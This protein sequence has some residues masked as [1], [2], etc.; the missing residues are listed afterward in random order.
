MKTLSLL[1][2]LL[3]FSAGSFANKC[4]SFMAPP[5]V[6]YYSIKDGSLIA[7]TD[8]SNVDHV[9][10]SCTCAPTCT[11]PSNSIVYIKHIITVSCDIEIGSNSTIIVE[12]GGA[13][14]VIGNGSISG[15]GNL[16][17]DAGASMSVSGNLNLSGTGTATINGQLD[18]VG[19]ITFSGTA[20]LCG[21]GSVNLGGNFEGGSPCGTLTLPVE[22]VYFNAVSDENEVEINWQ[23]AS[24]LNND[25]FIIERSSNAK[26]FD[27]IRRVDGAGT[28][29]QTIDYFERDYS[30]L[31]GTSYYRLRQV[32]FD[33]TPTLSNTVAVK[34]DNTLPEFSVY[35]NP[36]NDGDPFYM[37]FS[38]FGDEEV[39]VVLRDMQGREFYS[40]VI[41]TAA[42]NQIVAFD[43]DQRIPAGTYLVIASSDDMLYTQKLVVK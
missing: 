42:D 9:S 13:L 2:L 18:V 4:L 20:S 15:T 40:K 17:V 33:G 21:T 25:Y 7:T 22:L 30:P 11:V 19:N 39:L 8:W 27:E 1:T 10:P 14:V 38:G 41:I 23:T 6:S 36:V 31:P 32:D 29:N 24:E 5:A 34:R 37:N 35:P 26:E 28:S 3:L 16:Q 43:P 12:S